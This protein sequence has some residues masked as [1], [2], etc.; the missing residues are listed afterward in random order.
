[1]KR[2]LTPF[3][4]LALAGACGFGSLA[5]AQPVPQEQSTGSL[6]YING[7]ADLDEA[8]A[9]KQLAPQYPLRVLMADRSGSYDVATLMVVRQQDQVVAEIDN[10]GPWVLM[11]VPPGRYT[12]ETSF[13]NGRT[14]Q[15]Q[16]N[17]GPSGATL[18]VLAPDN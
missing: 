17:V 9:I 7:G 8:A 13:E 16:V 10:A 1:M 3:G 2:I 18:H 5:W 15:R 6:V 4:A 14:Q 12:V 11:K